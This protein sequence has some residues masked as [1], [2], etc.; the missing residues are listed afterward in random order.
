[1]G[2]TEA[3]PGGEGEEV[4]VVVGVVVVAREGRVKGSGHPESQVV[5]E[6]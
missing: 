1:M 4:G 3:P 5:E 2:Q 6:L